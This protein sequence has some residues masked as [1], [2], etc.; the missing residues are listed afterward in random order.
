MKVRLKNLTPIDLW[1]VLFT[2]LEQLLPKIVF[3]NLFKFWTHEDLC[4]LILMNL[5]SLM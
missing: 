4:S 2:K 3:L 5:Q 1:Q